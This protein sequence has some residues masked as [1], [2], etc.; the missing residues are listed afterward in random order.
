MARREAA[1]K[2]TSVSKLVGQI[3]EERFRRT[4]EYW[5]AFERMKKIKPVHGIGVTRLT[6]EEA[7]ERQR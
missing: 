7:N 2:N 4:A 3:L 5:E 1:D 6:R